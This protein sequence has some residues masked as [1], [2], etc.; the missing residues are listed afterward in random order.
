MKK[1]ILLIDDKAAA[2]H[3][4]ESALRVHLPPE[5][6]DV[7]TWQP[8]VE[9]VDPRQSFDSRVDAHTILVVTDYDLTTHGQMGLFGSTIVGWAQSRGIP[10]GDFSRGNPGNLPKEPNLFELRVP[11]SVEAGASFI[12]HVFRGFAAIRQAISDDENLMRHLRS[13]AAAVAKLLGRPDAESAFAL[14]G[15]RLGG[16]NGAL[17]ERIARTAPSDVE[18]DIEE[19]RL[20]LG[21]IVG[22]LLL[23]SILKFPGPILSREALCAYFGIGSVEFDKVSPLMSKARYT[24]PFCGL[25]DFFWRS[26]VDEQLDGLAAGLELDAPTPGELNREIIEHKLSIK[27]QRPTCT[28]CNGVNGGFLC[29]FTAR[30]VCQLADCSVGSS[31]WIPQGARI[32]RIERDFYD[33]WAPILGI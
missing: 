27:L 30:T 13:P 3:E 22:H 23:N 2:L 24:G 26:D 11:T 21:Y 19:K 9:D 31:S 18:P 28:R 32:S 20:L 25:S 15:V 7:R 14:Y 29:P 10:A 16:T 33:E 4:M 17:L 6:V 8:G 12:A 5:E 1:S